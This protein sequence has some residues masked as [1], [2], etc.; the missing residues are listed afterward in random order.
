MSY[1]KVTP[2]GEKTNC[3]NKK[4]DTNLVKRLRNARKCDLQRT[5]ARK[6]NKPSKLNSKDDCLRVNEVSGT[7]CRF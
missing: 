2:S 6:K 1:L 7:S 3:C 4:Y 5:T